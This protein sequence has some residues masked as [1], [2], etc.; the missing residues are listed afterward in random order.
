MPQTYA[1]SVDYNGGTFDLSRPLGRAMDA[2]LGA[3]CGALRT[4]RYL[5][6]Q[7]RVRC[8]CTATATEESDFAE[9]LYVLVIRDG[10]AYAAICCASCS[11]PQGSRHVDGVSPWWA[12]PGLSGPMI[13]WT[14]GEDIYH[15]SELET[16]AL[17]ATAEDSF[18]FDRGAGSQAALDGRGVALA[19]HPVHMREYEMASSTPWIPPPVVPATGIANE[20]SR[21]YR[22]RASVPVAGIA[23]YSDRIN[24]I[25]EHVAPFRYYGVEVETE[26]PT[27]GEPA[28]EYNEE[29]Y[30]GTGG[31]QSLDNVAAEIVEASGNKVL[32]KDDGSL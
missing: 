10:I 16:N 29:T 22:R 21:E 9:A 5:F 11:L 23:S 8:I 31:E 3:R 12:V 26:H 24:I 28:P 30:E 17:V 27:S 4:G 19:R 14:S 25:R 18:T 7:P 32:C 13:Q 15:A 20:G 6:T 2:L 1:T